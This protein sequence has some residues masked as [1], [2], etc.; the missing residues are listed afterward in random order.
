MIEIARA[1][2]P[3]ARQAKKILETK[4]EIKQQ[5][6]AEIAKARFTMEGTSNYP[7]ATFTL[8]LSYGTVRGYEENGKQ[9]PAFTNFAGLYERADQHKNKPPFDLPQR[10]IEKKDKLALTAPFNFVSD[11]DIIGGNSGSPVVNKAGEFVGIIFDGNIQ[12]L[13]LD[14]IFTDKQAR[15]VSVDSAAIIEALRNVYAAQPLVDELSS[16][17]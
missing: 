9:V 11:A 14:C 4:E 7:D 15:A 8:R 17:K 16:A 13:V 12:S 10:W 2:D 3:T 6:Y 5:A 1:I